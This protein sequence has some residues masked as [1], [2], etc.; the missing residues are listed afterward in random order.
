PEQDHRSPPD[1]A[2]TGGEQNDSVVHA[3]IAGSRGDRASGD[4]YFRRAV[5]GR[6]SAV[7]LPGGRE[8][9][10]RR[11]PPL[12]ARQGGLTAKTNASSLTRSIRA[13]AP[14]E[15]NRPWTF[16]FASSCCWRSTSSSSPS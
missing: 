14:N 9:A 10:G 16:S 3:H 1:D 2:P 8:V 4:R 7:G 11:I 13:S 5:G 15:G 12:D 6:W